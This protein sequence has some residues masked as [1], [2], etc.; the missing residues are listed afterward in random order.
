MHHYFNCSGKLPM[1]H[2]DFKIS[3]KNRK[4][5]LLAAKESLASY[6]KKYP[7]RRSYSPIPSDVKLLIIRSAQTGSD[8]FEVGWWYKHNWHLFTVSG[9]YI[10]YAKEL[11][12]SNQDLYQVLFLRREIIWRNTIF[13]KISTFIDKKLS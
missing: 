4:K 11:S 8:Y 12:K 6:R 9:I 5:R 3:Y 13:G 10:A 1:Q 7:I 2:K